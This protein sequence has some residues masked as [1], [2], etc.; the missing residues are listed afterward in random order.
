M[1]DVAAVAVQNAAQV[2]ERPADVEVGNIDVPM[3]MGHQRL[4]KAGALLRWLALPLRQQ[5]RLVED[6]PH[7][8]WTHRH[9]VGIQ[10]DERQPPITFQRVLQMEADNGLL[11]PILQ[12]EIA[13]NPAVVFVH[14]A[15]AFPP[16]VE[17]AGSHVEPPD[18]PPGA[19][20]GLLRP[21]PDEIHD[22]VP[23][24]VR[25][26]H[27]GQSSPSFF[28]GRHAPPSTRPGPHPWSGSSS[29]DRRPV[30]A[31]LNGWVEILAERQPPRSR[32]DPSAS[33]RTPWAGAP[34]CHTAPRSA[35]A[36]ADAASGWR[37]SFPACSASVASSCVRSII[38]MGERFLH[39]QLNRN[40]R[41]GHA[42]RCG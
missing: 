40:T 35:P 33:G 42:V 41:A 12:P 21:A 6:T 3:P 2:I 14:L 25:N 9:D 26:P 11:L 10:G 7:A 36:P 13:G 32:R 27:P 17:L 29:P 39:F 24:I 1:D 28:L 37:L 15:I 20:L 18:E 30:P 4:L 19:D 5:L 38:L 31:R 16:V 23:R 8:G 22:L 34:V